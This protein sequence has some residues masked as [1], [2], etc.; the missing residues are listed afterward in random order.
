MSSNPTALLDT[1]RRVVRD[2]MRS[3]RTATLAIVQQVQPHA[4]DGD[5][6]G[7]SATVALHDTEV[8]LTRVPVATARTGL[9]SIPAVGDMV[10]VQF[11]NGDVHQPVIVGS[12]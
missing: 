5:D 11:V 8:V 12:L 10:L 4:S 7:Y 3:L 1:I 2:E 6:D 9:A